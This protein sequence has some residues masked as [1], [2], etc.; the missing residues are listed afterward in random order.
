[1]TNIMMGIKKKTQLDFSS[2]DFTD[3]QIEA[4]KEI[5]LSRK[6]VVTVDIDNKE[7]KFTE[8]LGNKCCSHQFVRFEYRNIGYCFVSG[9][10]EGFVA[11]NLIALFETWRKNE[12][13]N[14]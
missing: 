8:I 1:M 11:D 5:V 9:R 4:I 2:K 10:V 3:E 13:K 12:A 6:F 14:I 7:E